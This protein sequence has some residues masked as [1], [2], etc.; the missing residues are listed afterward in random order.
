M[1]PKAKRLV[2][3]AL[4]KQGCSKLSE[5]G[6]HEKWRCPCGQHTTAVPRHNEVTAGVVRGI[7]ADLACLPKGWL[8]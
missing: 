5:R 1:K 7:I 3:A 8:Q 6:I 4:V 2:V